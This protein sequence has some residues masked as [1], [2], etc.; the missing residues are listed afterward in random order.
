M[1]E[2]GDRRR[3]RR[4]LA[5]DE[6]ARLPDVAEQRG[7]R[8]WYLTAALAGLR[9]SELIRLTWASV[10]LEQAVFTIRDG[11]VAEVKEYTDLMHT[12]E[13]FG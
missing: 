10:D 9:R 13:I 11:K 4:P 1:N 3:I 6:L 5:D 8:G 2:H 12:V 7:R